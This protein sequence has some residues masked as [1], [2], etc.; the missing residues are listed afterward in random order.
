MK[1]ILLGLALCV[2][3][4]AQAYAIDALDPKTFTSDCTNIRD[5]YSHNVPQNRTRKMGRLGEGAWARTL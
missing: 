3:F 2:V 4:A 1:K 5:D